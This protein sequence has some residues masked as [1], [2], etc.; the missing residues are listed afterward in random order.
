MIIQ[1]SNEI[2]DKFNLK[3]Q[4]Y[5]TKKIMIWNLVNKNIDFILTYLLYLMI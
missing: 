3:N 5:L 1:L 2:L 4:D